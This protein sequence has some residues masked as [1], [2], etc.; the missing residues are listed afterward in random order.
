MYGMEKDEKGPKKFAFDLEKEIA[1]KPSRGKEI[2]KLA[3]ERAAHLKTQL[4]EGA[5]GKEFDE[6]GILLHG[7]TA[8]QRVIKRVAK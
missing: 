5:S 3:Q 1:D 4:R 2:L 6:L 7:Y 8:L